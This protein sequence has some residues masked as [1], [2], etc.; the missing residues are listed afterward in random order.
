MPRTRRNRQS[1]D[2]DL[3]PDAA[4]PD[5]PASEDAPAP[6]PR[7]RSRRRAE[8]SPGLSEQR[9]M[10]RTG[11][12]TFLLPNGAGIECAN[13]YEYSE[14][15]RTA[16]PYVEAADDIPADGWQD[17]Q[18]LLYIALNLARVQ[19]RLTEIERRA[20]RLTTDE[21][22][23]DFQERWGNT[24]AY[25]VK[26]LSEYQKQF[27]DIRIKLDYIRGKAKQEGFTLEAFLDELRDTRVPEWA[28]DRLG[29]Y[30][31]M[32]TCPSA[33]CRHYTHP[34]VVIQQM[35]HFAMDFASDPNTIWNQ[36]VFELTKKYYTPR[37]ECDVLETEFLNTAKGRPEGY[38]SRGLSFRDAAR[39]LRLSTIGWIGA[40]YE[41]QMLGLI[42]FPIDTEKIINNPRLL[43]RYLGEGNV[44]EPIL[45]PD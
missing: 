31:W 20:Q 14:V 36:Q 3:T 21:E 19:R 42:E 11:E 44:A 10:E 29:E 7:R 12:F 13:G 18:N 33:D 16:N 26:Q 2:I 35:P 30:Q 1:D 5:A 6:P 22:I 8:T 43:A 24:Q 25:L 39:I 38:D 23:D 34:F 28:T 4:E 40:I 9:N 45:S 17:I 27:N 15:A 37:N 41:K 32:T